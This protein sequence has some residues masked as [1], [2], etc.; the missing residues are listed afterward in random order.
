MAIT[1]FL[2][3]GAEVKDFLN[4]THSFGA[5]LSYEKLQSFLDEFQFQRKSNNQRYYFDDPVSLEDDYLAG[6]KVTAG[7]LMASLKIG[8]W[9]VIIPGVRYE[10]T[11]NWYNTRFGQ[12]TRSADGDAIVLAATDTVGIW[13]YED[14][15]P[16]L[17]IRLNITDWMD[18]RMAA[19]RS[20]SRPDYQNLVPRERFDSDANE[21]YRGQPRLDRIQARNYDIAVSLYNS[22]YGLVSVGGFYKVIRNIDFI[23]HTPAFKY[24]SSQ[25]D[26]YQPENIADDA[27]VSGIETDVQTNLRF[28]PSPLDGIVLNLNY[29]RIKSK[30]TIPWTKFTPG[31]RGVPAVT[32]VTFRDGTM[33]GQPDEI[34]NATFGYE[35]GPFSGRLSYIYQAKVL[36][37]IGDREQTD[38]YTDA[39]KR[40]DLSL[41]YKLP[42]RI[43][44]T[45]NLNNITDQ[46]DRS[47]TAF[48][49][50]PTEEKYFG[51][52][53]EIGLKY[54]L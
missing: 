41:Q 24:G 48:G 53:A 1:S 51:W 43:A 35:K 2:D 12:V 45:V 32:Y 25:T 5:V 15:L 11:E 39:M 49:G 52:I 17:H 7:Y 27:Y 3:Q 8:Q 37:V 9:L 42:W 16:M 40:W 6:E 26:L 13:G 50:L 36:A 22:Y 23:R 38:G 10:K 30:V 34:A 21:L 44:L 19:T 47:I 29:A 28:L 31:S 33:P 46:P 14:I 20:I 18:L 54:E 4:G